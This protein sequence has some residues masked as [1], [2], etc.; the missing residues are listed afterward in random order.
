MHSFPNPDK[1]PERFLAWANIVGCNLE[2][3]TAYDIYKR[4]RICDI[5][6][7]DVH[8]NRFKRLNA[9]AVPTLY[10]PGKLILNFSYK[11]LSS[12]VLL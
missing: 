9:L 5:H 4:K 12:S 11:T 1:F 10:L 6:F 7:A 2:T 3:S 8:R